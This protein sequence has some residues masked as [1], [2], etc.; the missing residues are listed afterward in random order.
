MV[1]QRASSR[2]LLVLMI[3]GSWMMSRNASAGDAAP[4]AAS[5]SVESLLKLQDLK[6]EDL[7]ANRAGRISPRQLDQVA[8][9]RNRW[10]A[11][12]F[13]SVG[14]MIFTALLLAYVNYQKNHKPMVF[15]VPA[16]AVGIG[17][18]LYLVYVVF[19]RLPSGLADRKVTV[20]Q[21]PFQHLLSVPTRSEYNVSLDGVVY[22]GLTG[23][24]GD[25]LEG[26]TFKA[27]VVTEDKL[28]VA[29][30]PAP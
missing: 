17:L 29:F 10:T 4:G 7:E 24:L 19:L 9:H 20:I 2:L 26:K 3:G 14:A 18:A 12:L 8:S 11:V 22:R 28:I 21:A 5:G 16:I 25:N 13:T 27:Y 6:M 30:E 15:I 23:Q 1:A